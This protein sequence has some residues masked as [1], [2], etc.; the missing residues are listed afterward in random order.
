[1]IGI[2]K[3]LD[4]QEEQQNELFEL[5]TSKFI[6]AAYKINKKTEFVN[7]MSFTGAYLRNIPVTDNNGVKSNMYEAFDDK[8][9]IKDG[10]KLSETKS[11]KDFLFDVQI[12][13]KKLLVKSHGNY[14]TKMKG[15]EQLMGRALLQF[16]SWMPEM[17]ASRFAKVDYD[18]ILQ[19]EFKGRYRSY[20]VLGGSTFEGNQYT[21][22]QNCLYTLGQL[23]RKIV[24]MRT[25]FD[26]RMSTTDAANMRANLMELHFAIGAIIM[27]LI[28]RGA[29]GDDDDKQKFIR[30][31][32]L[33]LLTRT[34][35]DIWMYANPMEMESLS[36]NFLPVMGVISDTQKA[37]WS[38]QQQ[39]VGKGTYI[40][41]S[42]RHMNKILVN[43]AKMVPLENQF[44]RL[45]NYGAAPINVTK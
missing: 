7:M 32:A 43:T 42:H 16:R 28:L 10:W 11:N 25:S 6:E 40:T 22:A 19:T 4:I 8:G 45:F 29:L 2:E 41:G 26:G 20:K 3:S 15:K 24:F 34:Q 23:G 27:T 1:M 9:N 30:N 39:I 17:Y 33:N 13:V 44:L 36:K 18:P 12:N 21:M 38:V 14:W 35:T 31:M 5:G 37:L